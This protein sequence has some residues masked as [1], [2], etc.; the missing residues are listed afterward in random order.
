MQS[1]KYSGHA[2]EDW[3]LNLR[4]WSVRVDSRTYDDPIT[5]PY[6]DPITIENPHPSV[7]EGTSILVGS[8]GSPVQSIVCVSFNEGALKLPLVFL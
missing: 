7:S 4:D 8:C 5:I 3:C 1:E 2:D 6:D